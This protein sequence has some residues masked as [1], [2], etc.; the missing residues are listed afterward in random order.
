MPD[1]ATQGVPS[2]SPG[3]K[4]GAVGL[5]GAS[6]IGVAMLS[7]AM[8]VYMVFGASVLYAGKAGPLVF[9]IALAA[10]LP[11]ALSYALVA[12][13]LPSS[14]SAFAW[15]QKS[16][17]APVG[18]AVGCITAIYY[19]LNVLLQPITFGIFSRD[20]LELVG[21][22]Q[23]FAA[24]VI[25]AIVS[26]AVCAWL[27]YRGI[28]PSAHGALGFLAAE[29]AIIFMLALTVVIVQ[30][31]KGVL[32]A[33][34]FLPSSSPQG[35][36]GLF[37]GLVFALLAFCGFD[38]VST[39]AEEATASRTL[40][41]RATMLALVVFAIFVVAHAWAFSFS[42]PISAI[43]AD[44]QAGRLPVT[45]IAKQYWG[46]G[47]FV[48]ILTGLSATIGVFIATTVG[49][50]RVVYAIA[51]E[52]YLPAFLSE[53]DPGTR[54]PANALHLVFGVSIV[55]GIIA[56]LIL[57]PYPAYLWCGAASV[58]FAMVT[59][60]AVNLTNFMFHY[61]FRREHFNWFLHGVVPATGASLDLYVLYKS[62]FRELLAQSWKEGRSVVVFCVLL[63]LLAVWKAWT[64]RNTGAVRGPVATRA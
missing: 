18:V 50:S 2:P 55:G 16:I 26:S 15:A 12:R 3:L 45:E 56:V 51:R 59:Y 10:T 52:G 40:I 42:K 46:K 7:P 9:L 54:A 13:E 22:N 29:T 64:T 34:P 17:N 38:V 19:I 11:T 8:A 60:L 1:G 35:V 32:N 48:V 28:Q 58:F 6:A 5:I 36:S 63:A 47:Y 44:A 21:W 53:V 23:P 24:W 33:T 39:V 20:L 14:G 37:Q 27:V 4:A 31:P 62:F 25:G 41:P 57:G 30:A 49:A 43:A 61:R